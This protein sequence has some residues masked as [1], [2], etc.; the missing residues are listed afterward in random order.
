MNEFR[1]VLGVVEHAVRAC[2]IEKVVLQRSQNF[3]LALCQSPYN[4]FL[5][6]P[7]KEGCNPK[8]LLIYCL[9]SSTTEYLRFS[10]ETALVRSTLFGDDDTAVICFDVHTSKF[11]GIIRHNI[12]QWMVQN[13]SKARSLM[14]RG[15]LSALGLLD[16]DVAAMYHEKKKRDTVIVVGSG[17]REHALAVALAES[18]MVGTVLCCPGN[19]GTAAEQGDKIENVDGGKQDSEFVVELVKKTKAKMVVVGP[20]APLVAGLVDN[21]ATECPSVRVFGPTQAAAELEASKV[22][23]TEPELVVGWM[24]TS[25]SVL[26]RPT[27]QVCV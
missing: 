15:T 1:Q 24:Q 22:R 26:V 14:A 4:I 18:P 23:T 9:P 8:S 5:D 25:R 16:G 27:H 13:D 3:E 6:N 12:F 20:E 17:G 21:L 10:E 7:P 19:G 11:H 2:G